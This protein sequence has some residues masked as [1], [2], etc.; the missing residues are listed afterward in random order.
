MFKN[1]EAILKEDE[2]T[3]V[4]VIIDEAE[5]LAHARQISSNSSEPQDSMRVRLLNYGILVTKADSTQ[6]VNALLV[7]LDRLRYRNN[8]VVL[9]TSNLIKVMVCQR[10]RMS[11]ERSA[12]SST[13]TQRS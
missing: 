3:F 5:S 6:A 9:C 8:V 2:T 12:N 7:A 10:N 1:I 11:S 13:R 4:C